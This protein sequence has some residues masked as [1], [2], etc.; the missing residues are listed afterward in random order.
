MESYRNRTLGSELIGSKL[1]INSLFPNPKTAF[2]KL[3]Q[4]L[5]E[6]Y[7]ER[8]KTLKDS[9]DIFKNIS[10]KDPALQVMKENSITEKYID[11]RISELFHSTLLS[12]HEKTISSLQDE[13]MHKKSENLKLEQS[14]FS[15]KIEL[16]KYEDTL[17]GF[18]S[19]DNLESF[20]NRE[21]FRETL[22]EEVKKKQ[23]LEKKIFDMSKTIERAKEICEENEKLRIY[24]EQLEDERDKMNQGLGSSKQINTMIEAQ[25]QAG[26]ETIKELQHGF[27][28]KNKA[29]KKKIVDQKSVIQDL[30]REIIDLKKNNSDELNSTNRNQNLKDLKTSFEAREAEII[31]KHKQQI[32]SLQN[33]Y[34]NLLDAKI[35]EIQEQFSLSA[36]S[37]IPKEKYYELCKEKNELETQVLRLKDLYN[38]PE[39][40]EKQNSFINLKKNLENAEKNNRDLENR[41]FTLKTQQEISELRSKSSYNE[42]YENEITSH[43]ETKFKL[44]IAEEKMTDI[45]SSLQELQNSNQKL[46]E[47]LKSKE[48]ELNK[49]KHSENPEKLKSLILSLGKL[50]KSSS[51]LKI[52]LKNFKAFSQESL[53]NLYSEFKLMVNEIIIKSSANPTS[54][55]IYNLLAENK[56]LNELLKNNSKAFDKLQEEVKNETSRMKLKNQSL[57]DNIIAETKIKMNK[58][59]EDLNTQLDKYKQML[60]N[61]SVSA[62]TEASLNKQLKDEIKNLQAEKEKTRTKLQT[63]EQK[64]E[65]Q[66][67]NFKTQLKAKQTEI[68][69]LKKLIN[70]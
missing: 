35:K 20:S 59:V 53:A 66:T 45:N 52:H 11:Q 7:S 16:E 26:F 67:Q 10:N 38:V 12:E 43:A 6:K 62:Q 8:L 69:N 37:Y 25:K 64:I 14:I 60:E 27:K 40:F 58:E 70:N 33:Q 55:K 51:T 22:A 63:F 41:L 39:N 68:E 49:L 3:I 42:K 4:Y 15:Y 2:D 56:N 1:S 29:L 18:N 61:L 34:K 30:E 19:K 24:C 13:L 54:P 48:K 31:E 9:A 47:T 23:E 44:K 65:T 36:D 50:K 5:Q 17:R 32:I 21:N 57:I 46:K 28:K